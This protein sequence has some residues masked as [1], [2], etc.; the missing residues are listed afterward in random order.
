MVSDYLDRVAKALWDT[1][2]PGR[3]PLDEDNYQVTYRL[4][5]R[6]AVK[7][8]RGDVNQCPHGQWV[9]RDDDD[10]CHLCGIRKPDWARK[11]D[12]MRDQLRDMAE[13]RDAWKRAYMASAIPPPRSGDRLHEPLD[14]H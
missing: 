8:M 4:M 11:A 13:E 6:A 3:E 7:A 2:N 9:R 14:R 10:Y 5:A 12:I 1:R